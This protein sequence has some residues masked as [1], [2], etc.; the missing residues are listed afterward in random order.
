[1]ELIADYNTF[2]VKFWNKNNL[3]FSGIRTTE[4]Y[5]YKWLLFDLEE[6]II[7]LIRLKPYIISFSLNEEYLISYSN[8]SSP[9]N[10]T[11][12]YK[13]KKGPHYKALFNNELFEIILHK[14]NKVSFLKNQIQFA[15]LTEQAITTGFSKKLHIVADDDTNISFFCTLI[16]GIICTTETNDVNINFNFGNISAEL[17]QFDTQWQPRL[18]LSN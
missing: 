12:Y 17:K 3:I 6:N 2:E 5:R 10:L 7:S 13:V 9:Y 15:Y 18:K 8:N 1:M 16:Y 4:K 14:G 11:L